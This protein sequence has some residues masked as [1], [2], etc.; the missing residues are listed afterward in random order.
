[1]I[2]EIYTLFITALVPTLFVLGMVF[3]VLSRNTDS[4]V[5]KKALRMLIFTYCFYGLVGATQ[6]WSRLSMPEFENNDVEMIQIITLIIAVSQAFLFTFTMILL[7]HSPYV[8]KQRL[9]REIVTIFSAS[10]V[11]VTLFLVLPIEWRKIVIYSFVIFYVFLLVKYTRLFVMTFRESLQKMDNFFSGQEAE[12]LKW[13]RFSF[14]VALSI[15][16]LAL[17]DS[18]TPSIQSSAIC[19]AIYLVFYIYFAFRFISYGFV[20]QNIETVLLNSEEN[21]QAQQ[22]EQNS[23]TPQFH[24]IEAKLN[25]WIDK[26]LFLQSGI[27][28]EEVARHLGTNRTYLSEYFN[29]VQKVTFRQ[30]INGLRIEYAKT[31]MLQNPQMTLAEIAL[32]A[33]YAD[34][35]H[36]THQFSKIMGTLPNKWKEENVF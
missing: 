6:L 8:T 19:T 35:S 1:M 32:Q 3:Y 15:G 20:F 11:F 31:V 9:I 14:F 10:A 30:Y 36:F 27:T 28:I 13:I 7:I 17:T 12:R 26:Q 16:L 5:L 29:S 2:N 21:T 23:D 4:L 25:L 34:K 33:G 18:L 24:T 22:S